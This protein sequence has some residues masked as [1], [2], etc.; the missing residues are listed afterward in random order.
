MPQPVSETRVVCK[1]RADGKSCASATRFDGCG[2]GAD[3]ER[4]AVGHRVTRVR[5]EVDDEL[6]ELPAVDADELRYLGLE[7]Q[8][9]FVAGDS[10]GAASRGVR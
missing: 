10:A 1:S 4:S 6:L 2:F 7:R 5:D 3:R 9:H 8:G